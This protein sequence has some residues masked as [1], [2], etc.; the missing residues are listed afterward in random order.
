MA[1]SF[2]ATI[3]SRMRNAAIGVNDYFT[4]AARALRF[5]GSRPFYWR[6][7]LVQMDRIG[8]GAL[9]IVALT[10]LFTGMVV[11]LQ[12]SVE[13]AQYGATSFL[14]SLVGEGVVRELGPVLAGLGVAGRSGS[15]IAAE[16][17][18]MR[19]SEQIDALQTFG[20]RVQGNLAG[21]ARRLEEAALGE[22]EAP[23]P[24]ARALGG[25]LRDLRAVKLKP[26]K[27]RAK[28]LNR[29]DR[30]ADELA[31]LAGDG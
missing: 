5:L 31:E 2:A 1:R 14:G 29:I 17:G 3:D 8:V 28:D 15:A 26:R 11:A 12:G 6:D 7:L 30:V 24:S 10:G 19:V 23:L 13:L 25:L 4:L 20:A 21:A 22:S 16:L 9:P 18:A 27:G